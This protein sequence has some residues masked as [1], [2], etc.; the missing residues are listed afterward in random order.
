MSVSGRSFWQ[1]IRYRTFREP[2]SDDRQPE[3]PWVGVYMACVGV[4]GTVSGS[5]IIIHQLLHILFLVALRI[6][7]IDGCSVGSAGTFAEKQHQARR[8]DANYRLRN[9]YGRNSNGTHYAT[10][11]RIMTVIIICS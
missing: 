8:R 10:Y 2:R 5:A 11:H 6:V 9:R 4:L 7:R 1:E 3:R